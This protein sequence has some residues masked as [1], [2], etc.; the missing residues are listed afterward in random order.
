MRPASFLQTSAALTVAAMLILSGCSGGGGGGV[1]SDGGPAS[2]GGAEQETGGGDT[3]PGDD[4][5]T[6]TDTGQP[7]PEPSGPFEWSCTEAGC[8][9]DY[10]GVSL[11]AGL[12]DFGDGDGP[13]PVFGGSA[14]SGFAGPLPQGTA[15]YA[16]AAA[17]RRTT[18]P[19]GPDAET[20]D[21]TGTVI[22]TADFGTNTVR[23]RLDGSDGSP[24]RLAFNAASLDRGAGAPSFE[25]SVFS[26]SPSGGP[27]VTCVAGIACDYG[28]WWGEFGHEDTVGAAFYA[29]LDGVPVIGGGAI[30]ARTD[31]TTEPQPEPAPEP[32]PEPDDDT[33]QPEPAPDPGVA[34][35]DWLLPG[36]VAST[37]ARDELARVLHATHTQGDGS[38]AYKFVHLDVNAARHVF[39]VVDQ[40]SGEYVDVAPD[41]GTYAGSWGYWDDPALSGAITKVQEV[42]TAVPGAGNTSPVVRRV[43]GVM[44]NGYFGIARAEGYVTSPQ[45]RTV[46]GNF[47]TFHEA[48]SRMRA[49]MGTDKFLYEFGLVGAKWS[50]DALG[51]SR[52]SEAPVF[53]P[54]SLTVTGE[55]DG[56]RWRSDYEIVVNVDWNNGDSIEMMGLAGGSDDVGLPHPGFFG[57]VPEDAE[58][59]YILQGSFAGTQVEEAFGSFQTPEY[60]GSFGLKRQ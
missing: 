23:G 3:Q 54:A 43:M 7:A 15:H 12:H 56:S 49:A 26:P 19:S 9:A 60:M 36:S 40:Y 32:E 22:L 24:V 34:S 51:F 47:G 41:F 29:E 20:V 16:G 13:E 33:T 39:P 48:N 52:S 31:I 27:G 8:T 10:R 17:F 55:H 28:E 45:P 38:H 50:G 46:A 6:G 37:A 1:T 44:D 18:G 58:S 57:D 53:G 30:A 21:E 59:T 25:T 4:T 14:F 42:L 5:Q 35:P 2:P 11:Q